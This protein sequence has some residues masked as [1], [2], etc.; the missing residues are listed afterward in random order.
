MG[1]SERA[2]CSAPVDFAGSISVSRLVQMMD[3]IFGGVGVREGRAL[4][5][6]EGTAE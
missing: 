1:I 2:I 3:A 6:E 4:R 5:S